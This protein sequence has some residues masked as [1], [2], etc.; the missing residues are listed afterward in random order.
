MQEPTSETDT[1]RSERKI[2][3]YHELKQGLTEIVARGMVDA[4]GTLCSRSCAAII[5]CTLA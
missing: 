1:D 4:L 5:P 3:K 2:S